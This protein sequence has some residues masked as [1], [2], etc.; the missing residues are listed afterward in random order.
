M[1]NGKWETVKGEK[2]FR[3]FLSESYLY[4]DT[5]NTPDTLYNM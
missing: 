2:D 3:L 4:S 5:P 1:G